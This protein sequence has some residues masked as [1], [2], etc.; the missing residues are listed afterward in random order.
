MH[1]C[2]VADFSD[3]ARHSW[4]FTPFKFEATAMSGKKENYKVG[5][6]KPPKHSRFQ[7][8]QSGNPNGRPKGKPTFAAALA[9]ELQK[10][11]VIVEHGRRKKLTKLEASARQLANKAAA[12]ELRAI[13]WIFDLNRGQAPSEPET[14]KTA[15]QAEAHPDPPIDFVHGNKFPAVTGKPTGDG[16][17]LVEIM[18]EIYG[19]DYEY[20]RKPRNITQTS[21][22]SDR[23]LLPPGDCDKS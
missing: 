7:P 10:P 13:G 17:T 23:E 9:K 19:I 22:G 12:G 5:Y 3:W 1:S 21:R 8:G 2:I 11:V 14:N 15:A 6:G 20:T 18:R 4:K 16:R